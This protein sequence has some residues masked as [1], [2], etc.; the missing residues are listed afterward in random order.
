MKRSR[1]RSASACARASACCAACENC[2]KTLPASPGLVAHRE[3]LFIGTPLSCRFRERLLGQLFAC[4]RTPQRRNQASTARLPVGIRET[5]RRSTR[6]TD[7]APESRA[8]LYMPRNSA[9]AALTVVTWAVDKLHK[10][11]VLKRPQPAS[12]RA[13]VVPCRPPELDEP[14]RWRSE[15]LHRGSPGR[16]AMPPRHSILQAQPQ[17][18]APLPRTQLYLAPTRGGHPSSQ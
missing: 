11:P 8:F 3:L 5:S 10:L 9:I 16:L 15:R 12:E 13:G 17:R 14:S 18:R 1:R 2:P 7:Q 6:T 4:K